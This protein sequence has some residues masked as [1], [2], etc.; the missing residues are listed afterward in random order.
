MAHLYYKAQFDAV[1]DDGAFTGYG[2]I[3][4]NVDSQG[5]KVMPYAFARSLKELGPDVPILWQHMHSEPIGRMTVEEDARGLRVKNAR[6]VLEV[7]RGREAHALLKAGVIDG[8]SI[9]YETV[10][11]RT[12]RDGVRELHEL[13]LYEVSLVTFPANALA[14]VNAVKDD[15]AAIKYLV[16]NLR[17]ARLAIT[18]RDRKDAD[19]LQAL[20]DGIRKTRANISRIHHTW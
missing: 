15:K 2:S 12:D 13:R 4:G 5:D 16:A 19:E 3:A 1:T 11:A 18:D 14:R 17:S 10:K 20:L 9:G 8:L 6:L 7:Q